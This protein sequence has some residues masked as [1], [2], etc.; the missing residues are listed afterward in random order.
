MPKS[1]LNAADE[2]IVVSDASP[3]FKTPTRWGPMV[4]AYRIHRDSTSKVP[5]AEGA[6]YVG[7]DMG[8][9]KAE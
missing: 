5:D 6:A 4:A 3:A 2:W 1:Q 8:I 9:N 7:T